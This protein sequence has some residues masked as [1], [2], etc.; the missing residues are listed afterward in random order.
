MAEESP[1]LGEEMRRMQ[2]E[3]LLP[4]E[5]RLIARS[6][7]LGLALLLVLGWISAA[8]RGGF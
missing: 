1:H 8:L 3:E 2:H 4:V 5:R 7:I 6:L